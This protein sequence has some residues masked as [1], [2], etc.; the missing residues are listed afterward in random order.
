MIACDS[1]HTQ[2]ILLMIS[3]HGTPRLESNKMNQTAYDIQELVE[4]Q[5]NKQHD[6]SGIPF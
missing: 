6:G 2:Q 5:N 1:Q 4:R 3:Y